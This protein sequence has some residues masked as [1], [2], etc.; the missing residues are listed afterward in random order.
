LHFLFVFFS[1]VVC[2]MSQDE[3]T[4]EVE[5]EVQEEPPGCEIKRSLEHEFHSQC[6][7]P[8]EEYKACTRRIKGD[9]TGEANCK[10]Q[11]FEYYACIDRLVAPELFKR[12]K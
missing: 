7:E 12:L 10:G 5:E 4:P 11:Y 8:W 1:S 2:P 3:D 9:T 6:S